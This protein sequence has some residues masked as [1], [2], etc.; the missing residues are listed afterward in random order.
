[1]GNK[2]SSVQLGLGLGLSLAIEYRIQK[3]VLELRLHAG[4][5]GFSTKQT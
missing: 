5:R 1:M 2:T 4:A 3:P